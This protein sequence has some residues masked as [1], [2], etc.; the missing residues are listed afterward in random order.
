MNLFAWMTKWWKH[1]CEF[2]INVEG[3]LKPE[4]PHQAARLARRSI[5]PEPPPAPPK[6][7]FGRYYFE[8]QKIAISVDSNSEVIINAPMDVSVHVVNNTINI[9]TRK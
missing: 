5:R 9:T 2:A 7:G 6:R 4:C 1:Q 8:S 3:C